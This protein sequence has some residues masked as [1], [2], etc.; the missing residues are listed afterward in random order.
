MPTRWIV[1]IRNEVPLLD[2]ASYGR[3]GP[4]RR[5]L[6][7]AEFAHVSRTVRRVPEVL[8]KGSGGARS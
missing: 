3:T 8:V 1:D 5:L 2:V 6:S 4:G 7:K